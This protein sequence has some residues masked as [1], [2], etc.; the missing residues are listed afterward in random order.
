MTSMRAIVH[1]VPA[2]TRHAR[3][4]VGGALAG[5]FGMTDIYVSGGAEYQGPPGGGP[6]A[7]IIEKKTQ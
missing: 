6:V 3:A 4:F 7:V 2:E 1:R 5:Q